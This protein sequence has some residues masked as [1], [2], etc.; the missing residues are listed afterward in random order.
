MKL[1]P[2]LFAGINLVQFTNM[3]KG[4]MGEKSNAVIFFIVV[5]IMF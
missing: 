1:N 2:A 4:L 5:K 3:L